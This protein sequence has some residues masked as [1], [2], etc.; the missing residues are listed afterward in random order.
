MAWNK[1]LFSKNN[2]LQD[3]KIDR[4]TYKA[5]QTQTDS[6]RPFAEVCIIDL[7]I[8]LGYKIL[9]YN[10][11]LEFHLLILLVQHIIFINLYF[12][13]TSRIGYFWYLYWSAYNFNLAQ[14]STSPTRFA[15]RGIK[16]Q[17]A[18]RISPLLNFFYFLYQK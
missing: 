3:R 8:Q 16:L 17:F 13:K 18:K 11:Q 6:E 2:Y 10:S 1:F 15:R 4:F 14:Y 7:Y 12:I 9:T 5:I